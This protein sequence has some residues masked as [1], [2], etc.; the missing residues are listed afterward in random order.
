METDAL[1]WVPDAADHLV[2]V[3]A[4]ILQVH[5]HPN[6]SSVAGEANDVHTVTVQLLAT[7]QEVDVPLIL[8][9][10]GECRNVL[11]QNQPEELDQNDLVT[12]PHLHEASILHSLRVRYARDAIYTRIG[13]ILISINPFKGLP[14]LYTHELVD[15]YGPEADV[16]GATPHLYAIARAAYVDVVRNHR[17][18]SILISGESGAG[19]TEA[20]KIMM[21]YFALTCGT[22]ARDEDVSSPHDNISIESQ[23]LQ[24]NPIL[25]AFGNARTERNDNSSRFGK[26]I[27]LQFDAVRHTIVGA[28]IR[29]Y[30][31]EKI[32]V[33]NQA[34]NERNFH[35]F[36][37]LIAAAKSSLPGSASWCLQSAEHYRILHQ[38]G[39]YTRRDGVDDAAQFHRTRRA[40]QQIGL[41]DSEISNV[42]EIVSAML[43]MGNISF[44]RRS[45]DTENTQEAT[46]AVE[47]EAFE[48][49]AALLRVSEDQLGFSLTKRQLRTSTET[50]TVGMDVPQAE[51]TRN[52]L[53]MECYRLLFAWL[54]GRI[55]A[56]IHHQGS[57]HVDCIGLL[58]I[59]GFEDMAV[60]SFEQLCINYA[61]EALQHQ[62]NEFVFEQE[63]RLYRDEGIAWAFVDFPNNIA[64]LELFERKPLGLFSLAD[65]ECLFPQGTDRALLSKYYSEFEKKTPHPHFLP[66]SSGWQRQSHFVVAHYAG[67]VSYAIEGFLAKNKDS[68]CENAAKLLA[69][70]TNPLVQSLSLAATAA[71]STST[72]PIDVSPDGV[73]PSGLNDPRSSGMRRV[74]SSIA[75]VSV[76]TQFKLQLNELLEIIRATAPHY[77]R[78][79]KPNDTNVCDAF[80]SARVVEQLRS[81]GVL[82]AVRVARAG[83]PVRM[84]HQQFLERYQRVLTTAGCGRQT[85]EKCLVRLKEVITS[86]NVGVSLGRTRV[87]FRRQPYEQ[88]EQFRVQQLKGSV[89]LIQKTVRGYG[90]R[91]A[92]LRLRATVLRLQSYFRGR[93]AR[94]FTMWL[95]ETRRATMLQTV[96]RA[97]LYR[98]RFMRFRRAVL[99]CQTNWRRRVAAAMVQE[100]REDRAATRLAAWWRGASQCCE[101]RKLR[102]AVVSLQCRLRCRLARRELLALRLESRNVSKL[103]KDNQ[104]LQSQIERMRQEMLAMQAKMR[105]QTPTNSKVQTKVVD[106]PKPTNSNQQLELTIYA[107]EDEVA[108]PL[109]PASSSNGSI[110]KLGLSVDLRLSPERP[111][112]PPLAIQSGVMSVLPPSRRSSLPPMPA[113]TSKAEVKQGGGLRRFSLDP[114]SQHIVAT[115]VRFVMDKVGLGKKESEN[116]EEE[117]ERI[118]KQVTEQLQATPTRPTLGRRGSGSG[119]ELELPRDCD[120]N[121]IIDEDAEYQDD[122]PVETTSRPS[123]RVAPLTMCSSLRTFTWSSSSSSV[124]SPP[125]S[126][127]APM[128]A[129]PHRQRP[130]FFGDDCSSVDAMSTRSDSWRTHPSVR[131]HMGSSGTG[132]TAS[133]TTMLGSVPR[134]CKDSMCKACHCKFTFLIRRHHCRSCGNSFCFEHSTRRMMLSD[135]GYY[136]PQRVCDDC[137]EWR[138]LEL[139][140]SQPGSSRDSESSQFSAAV[141]PLIIPPPTPGKLLA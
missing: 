141:R 37:E 103:Q 104:Q 44:V 91:H 102:S 42:L 27:E 80:S 108:E 125:P 54:V 51:H 97:F 119:F 21:K 115:T 132:S 29:T 65:Q 39:C 136:E 107:P 18:Q 87:F 137:F 77:V 114:T 59:F 90:A 24:S 94:K 71:T 17:N 76:G 12:L 105:E 88:L 123:Q 23:V 82:E 15:S 72:D 129:R 126:F 96:I 133:S 64:C 116:P 127:G 61:N 74:K 79:I 25:E 67:K 113:S 85:L 50:L 45:N 1:V 78:C 3:S 70:S 93:R 9:A 118:I 66:P 60:N 55:N 98:A 5:T 38:S 53:V 48:T 63:Q 109:T 41:V 2:W 20:T 84:S 46:I 26:F 106:E 92:F 68:F 100:R 130:R 111:R 47:R 134:W 4:R 86:A 56:K 139:H 69:M 30:L 112:R 120:N 6:D 135:L 122:E 10:A 95:R 32:R 62:F 140:S 40:M 128:S 28:R 101:F 83:F 35:I 52:A 138:T 57:T 31:L 43:H 34:A 11:L 58:D 131:V 73:T 14:A 33:I 117:Q 81:G 22:K 89:V 8:T 110:T 49:A 16:I 99:H 75:A 7:G 13:E 121:S 19:K 36:Y 124:A